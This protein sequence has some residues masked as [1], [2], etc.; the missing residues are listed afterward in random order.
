M[1]ILT[2]RDFRSHMAS[3]LD[4]VDA[5]ERVYIRRNHKLYT[6]V[7]VEEDDME[8]TTAFAAKIEAARKELCDGDSRSIVV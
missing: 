4:R 2:I 5:G 7:R 3:T 1:A 8:I 6:V